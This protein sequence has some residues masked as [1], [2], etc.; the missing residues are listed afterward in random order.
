MWLKEFCPIFYPSYFKL[1]VQVC[2]FF[3]FPIENLLITNLDFRTKIS[4][5]KKHCAS[6]RLTRQQTLFCATYPQLLKNQF[7]NSNY[8]CQIICLYDVV[9]HRR[10]T[11]ECYHPNSLKPISYLG[12]IREL[13]VLGMKSNFKKKQK[14]KNIQILKTMDKGFTVSRWVL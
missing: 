8:Y 11:C 3:F 7:S 2:F 4:K 12:V 6:R 5:K 14:K 1:E 13:Y 10:R 9:L